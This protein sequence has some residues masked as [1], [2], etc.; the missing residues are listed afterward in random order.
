[1]EYQ[2][3]KQ[4]ANTLNRD[5][6]GVRRYIKNNCPTVKWLVSRDENGQ[7]CFVFDQED[8]NLILNTRTQ[9]GYLNTTKILPTE[10]SGKFY[11]IQI[12][13]DLDPKRIKLGFTSDLENRLNAHKTICPQLKLLANYPCKKIWEKTSIQYLKNSSSLELIGGEVFTAPDIQKTLD[14]ANQLFLLLND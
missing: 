13:P 12:I 3:L 1:M 10:D 7:K 11:V 4:L 8:V 6:S 5:I 2:T 9:Q 14:V